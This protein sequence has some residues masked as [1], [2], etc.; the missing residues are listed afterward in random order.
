MADIDVVP[1]HRS[2]TWLWIVLAI[3]VIAVL[4]WAFA[5]RTHAAAQLQI[6]PQAVGSLASRL[7]TGTMGVA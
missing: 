5:G 7:P 6:V 3:V 2:N 4:I 1:K